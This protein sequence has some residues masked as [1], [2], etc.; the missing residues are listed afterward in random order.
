MWQL[1]IIISR[2]LHWAFHH[3]LQSEKTLSQRSHWQLR[4][5]IPHSNNELVNCTRTLLLLT[6]FNSIKKPKSNTLKSGLWAGWFST[7][8]LIVCMTTT[9]HSFHKAI[10]V[11]TESGS[12]LA[13]PTFLDS[14]YRPRWP[15]DFEIVPSMGH[16]T[17]E[18]SR[19]SFKTYDWWNSIL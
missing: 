3:L 16:A 8:A 9:Q 10:N 11:R 4:K 1:V 6:A 13:G 15:T 18:P 12:K 5:G 2:N 14:L 17:N 19:G 7:L